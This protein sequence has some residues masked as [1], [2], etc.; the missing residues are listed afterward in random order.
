MK[1]M[2]LG[3]VGGAVAIYLLVFCLSVY[4]ISVRKNEM[5]NCISQVLEQNLLNY[6]GSESTD[7]EVKTTVVQDLSER[8]QAD[9]K[10]QINVHTCNIKQGILSVDLCE[11]F[12]LPI[13]VS[14]TIR[15]SK[16]VIA[17]EEIVEPEAES[18]RKEKE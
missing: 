4:S 9:S 10:V 7:A 14:K 18:S 3:M 6:Y 1:N 5:E 13:G 17:E 15:C 12:Y 2:I 16:T 8:L 11:E